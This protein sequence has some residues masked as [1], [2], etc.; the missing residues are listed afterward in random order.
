[1]RDI[2]RLQMLGKIQNCGFE[3]NRGDR[4]ER[5]RAQLVIDIVKYEDGSTVRVFSPSCTCRTK[6]SCLS[7]GDSLRLTWTLSA[8]LC[9][10]M[11]D[12]VAVV[13]E[14]PT[15]GL[16]LEEL[17]YMINSVSGVADDMDNQLADEFGAPL[18]SEQPD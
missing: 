17:E 4:G 11:K 2:A 6:I 9:A 12:K 18:F 5:L 7:T 3:P 10:S 14:R 13:S 15:T 1:M 8:V 16:D